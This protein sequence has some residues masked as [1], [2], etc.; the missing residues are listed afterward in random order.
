MASMSFVSK[1]PRFSFPKM[2]LLDP[3]KDLYRNRG[4]IESGLCR[5]NYEEKE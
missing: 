5:E 1:I 3:V 2:F 4:F